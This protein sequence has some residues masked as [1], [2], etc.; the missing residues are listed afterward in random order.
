MENLNFF[1]IEIKKLN[2]LFENVA[3]GMMAIFALVIIIF[4]TFYGQIETLS[5]VIWSLLNLLLLFLRTLLLISFNKDTLTEQNFT[6]YYVSFFILT[7]LTAALWGSSALLILPDALE[8]KMILLLLVAGLISGSVVSLASKVEI[9]YTYL[10][11]AI[12]PFIVVFYLSDIESS[13]IFAISIMVYVLVLLLL[14]RKTSSS[15]TNNIFFAEQNRKLVR[16]LEEKVTE[17]NIANRAKSEFLS[18]MSH[19]IR[20]PLNAILGFVQILQRQEENEKKRKYLDTIDKSSKILLSLINDILDIAKIESGKFT[21]EMRAFNPHEEFQSLAMLFEKNALEKQLTFTNAIADD[22]PPTLHS[23]VLRIKQILSNLLSNAIKFT[24]ESKNVTLEIRFDPLTSSLHCA[25]ID[26][27]IGISKEHIQNIT[28]AF[29]QAD[30]STARKYGGT[31]LGL[32]IVT[33]LLTLF[34]SKLTIE[35]IPDQGS[36]FSFEIKVLRHSLH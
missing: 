11:L 4:I 1:E 8:Y 6:T 22:L 12:T 2:Y 17:A 14:S 29:T 19:E 28:Q 16:Q 26:E 36:R 25:I 23:D 9:F 10:L 33:N 34:D 3:S 35:S 24:P 13:D 7:G 27:G 20:T 32:S 30:S 21:L 5:L 31:G 15:V 18:V